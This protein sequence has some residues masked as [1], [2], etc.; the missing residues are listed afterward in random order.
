MVRNQARVSL[1]GP[2]R[3]TTM[4]GERPDDESLA[5][6]AM[7]AVR[8]GLADF[9]AEDERD[10]VRLARQCL[11][12]L[13]WRK[14][15]PAPRTALPP[16]PRYDPEE[17]LA[18]ASADLR[19]S[20]DPREV[21]A[22]VLDGSV[23]DEFKPGYGAALVTG[24]G[25]LHGYP[26][27]VVANARGLVGSAEAQKA[28]QFVQLANAVD[29]PLLFLQNAAGQVVGAQAEQ[30]GAVKHGAMVLG[31]VANSRVPH[32]TVQ[33]GASYGVGNYAMA[34]RSFGPRF[35]F[36]WPN[37]KT[38]AM[39][40]G[41]LAGV[42]SVVAQQS[43]GNAGGAPNGTRNGREKWDETSDISLLEQRMDAESGALF[44]SG[45]LH[46][47]GVIDPR[48]TRTVLGICLSAIASG[49][50]EGAGGYGVLRM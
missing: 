15:G 17:L 7:H 1:A 18:I 36:S 9:L 35:L 48:D 47:D 26:V 39:P 33:I 50:I 21:L 42:L 31:A 44:L 40:P 11:R 38:A 6:A 13:N 46:D 4:T 28:A 25:E 43:G 20:F 23:F 29:A 34:G 30:R 8:S 19:V 3:V 14:A 49:P 27:G 22:R 12:R 24:W 2:A 41:Q 32:L 10:A 37:A 5:G 16:E 45:R